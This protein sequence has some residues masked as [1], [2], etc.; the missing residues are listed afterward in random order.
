MEICPPPVVDW[1]GERA[2]EESSGTSGPEENF[3]YEKG[4]EENFQKSKEKRSRSKEQTSCG[5]QVKRQGNRQKE[6][7]GLL[8]ERSP[9]AAAVLSQYIAA[10]PVSLRLL[11][12]VRKLAQTSSTLLIRGESGTGKDLL[13]FIIHYLGPN[14]D[15]PIINID[16]ASLPHELIES[17]LFGYERG[18]FTGATHLKRGRMEMAG[19][20]TLVLNEIAALTTPMQAKL[21]RAIEEHKLDRLGGTQ[22]I[23]LRARLVS[24][25]NVDLEQAVARKAF[26]EDLYYRLNV[27]PLVLSPLRERRGDILPLAEH[28]LEQ[29]AEIHRRPKNKLSS[30]AAAA[31]E[32]HDFPGNV[33]ELRNILERAVIHGSGTRI[34]LEDL[35]S[36]MQGKSSHRRETLE[37]LER[38]YIAEILDHTRGK[39]SKAAEILGISRKTLL[40]K[41]KRYKLD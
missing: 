6:K 19:D 34:E 39:K 3:R 18:A 2:S 5:S 7:E 26:R 28:F 14:A 15:E 1:T 25:T 37:V 13:A 8:T 20:G 32:A 27:V 16:C 29:L 10:D 9:E 41:R 17:E 31:L 35:P 36:Y 22:P 23:P 12:Q 30:Q 24:I 38:A 11:E 33:R 40:E 4:P 21:L